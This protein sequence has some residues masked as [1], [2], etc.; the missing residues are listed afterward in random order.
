MAR[1]V[2]QAAIDEGLKTVDVASEPPEVALG[3]GTAAD[4]R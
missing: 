2:A 4:V 3:R 1:R